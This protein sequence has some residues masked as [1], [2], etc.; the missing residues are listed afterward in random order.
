MASGELW[1]V[2]DP[3]PIYKGAVCQNVKIVPKSIDSTSHLVA[4]S[5]FAQ[6]GKFSQVFYDTYVQTLTSNFDAS[7]GLCECRFDPQFDGGSALVGQSINFKVPYVANI[8][9]P[10]IMKSVRIVQYDSYLTNKDNTPASLSE[11]T[12]AVWNTKEFRGYKAG[13][14]LFIGTKSITEGTSLYRRETQFLYDEV[15]GFAYYYAVWVDSRGLV[16]G[17]NVVKPYAPGELSVPDDS[18][19]NPQSLIFTGGAASTPPISQTSKSQKDHNGASAFVM[20]RGIDFNSAFS[21][22]KPPFGEEKKGQ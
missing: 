11:N 22:I 20:L 5:T 3:H 21:S 10:R 12:F 18:S 9:I 2:G 15:R 14:L 13:S 1:A 19:T 16:P 6:P 8:Q 17:G 4:M 7:G